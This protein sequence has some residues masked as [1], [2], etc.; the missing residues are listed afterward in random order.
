[1][2]NGIVFWTRCKIKLE[3]LKI[4][5]VLVDDNYIIHSNYFM[6]CFRCYINETV[7]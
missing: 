1:M 4:S 3:G 7:N 6:A 5:D 2:D